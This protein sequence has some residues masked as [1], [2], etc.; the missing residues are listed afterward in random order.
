MKKGVCPRFCYTICYYLNELKIRTAFLQEAITMT[1]FGSEPQ[2]TF[3]PVKMVI[4]LGVL[5]IL[6]GGISLYVHY[7]RGL[8][9]SPGA[10]MMAVTG[11]LRAGNTDFEYYR[12]RIFIENPKGTLGISFNGVR[13][14]TVSGT[15]VNGGDRTLEAVELHVTLYDAWGK[16][17]KEKTAFAFRPGTYNYKPLLPLERRS[18]AI[19][20]EA[21]EIYW[22]PKRSTCEVTGLKY[23]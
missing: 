13:T 9:P 2:K 23:K 12:T 10:P 1:E 7:Q 11:V 17:S 21:V 16:V 14:A 5:A 4:T 6:I 19:S 22:D 18:F 15:L 20:I 8:R 3:R